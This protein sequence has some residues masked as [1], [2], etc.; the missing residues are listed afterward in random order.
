VSVDPRQQPLEKIKVI[1]FKVT[2]E[3][4]QNTIYIYPV[5]HD[6]YQLGIIDHDTLTSFLRFCVLFWMGHYHMKKQQF[7]MREQEIEEEKK[8]LDAIIAEKEAWHKWDNSTPQVMEKA[9][10]ELE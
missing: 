2:E 5:M 8:K 3:E 10:K 7:E 4:L 1:E 6:C 9:V